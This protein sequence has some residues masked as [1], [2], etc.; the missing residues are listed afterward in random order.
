MKRLL[1][2]SHYN[3]QGLLSSYVV[4][5]LEKF[6]SLFER[7][8]F[9]SNSKI[10]LEAKKRILPFTDKILVRENIGFDFGAWKQ[11]ILEEGWDTLDSYD[12]LT[13]MND[14]CFGPFYDMQKV[15]E[16]MESS[17]IDFWGLTNHK[18][19]SFGMPG[20]EDPVPEHIQ[21]YFLSFN[22]KIIISETFANFW[23]SV[24]NFT[25]VNEVILHYE[26][27]LASVFQK[28]GFT[29]KVYCDTNSL[30]YDFV[31][32]TAFRPDY[33]IENKCPFIKVKGF[34]QFDNPFYLKQ[35]VEK[36]TYYD[37]YLIEDH[38]NQSYIPD[39]SLRVNDK[40]FITNQFM[41][42][43]VSET[44]KVA[45]HFH[46][47]YLDIF[48]KYLTDI[49]RFINQ[50]DLYIT[51]D[52]EEKKRLILS[53]LKSQPSFFL[54]KE[55]SVAEGISSDI[56]H[57]LK[58]AD[59]LNKYDL[60]GHFHTIKTDHKYQFKNSSWSEE[61]YDTLLRPANE[62]IQLF[63][64]ESQLGVLISDIPKSLR[65]IF[66]KNEWNLSKDAFLALWKGMGCKKNIDLLD[67]NISVVPY[68]NMFWYRPKAL[69]PLFELKLKMDD[70]GQNSSPNDGPIV[71]A[72]GYLPV[73][74]AWNQGYDFK[75]ALS[76]NY[77]FSGFYKDL[78]TELKIE[79]EN[80]LKS[81]TW[82]AG[83]F[84]TWL[85][86]KLSVSFDYLK[87]LILFKRYNFP[88][89]ESF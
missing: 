2:F 41:E 36:L 32:F 72:I 37:F 10:D 66:D 76:R 50:V 42:S 68:G 22:R 21:S 16:Q 40:V 39:I 46:V 35:L 18:A 51:T 63:E 7:V 64:K 56:I 30:N 23:N 17:E 59:D 6:R 83:L 47:N 54:I 89:D 26:T 57:W 19:F 1:L 15:F 88:P 34:L 31:N 33:F 87:K 48:E 52:S 67:R 20:S 5:I 58:L 85:P 9:V 60:V 82:K 73:Y 12:S 79:H 61:L 29:C 71:H 45:I 65:S 53:R 55:I 81:N 3:Q 44:Q 78:L 24:Q 77:I 25:D 80:V 8:V 75:I 74:V 43:S 69:R 13:I 27:Q 62:I 14:T 11:A 70:F 38:F 84:V 4:F 28:S 86:K 49:G